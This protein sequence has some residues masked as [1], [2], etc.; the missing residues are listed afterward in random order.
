MRRAE[1][2]YWLEI[3]WLQYILGGALKLRVQKSII[4]ILIGLLKLKPKRKVLGRLT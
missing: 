2:I 4:F 3:Y 1:N